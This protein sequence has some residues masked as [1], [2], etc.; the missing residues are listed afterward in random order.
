MYVCIYIYAYCNV[1]VKEVTYEKATQ[2][3]EESD[4]SRSSEMSALLRVPPVLKPKWQQQADIIGAR[5]S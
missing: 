5:T 1:I 2:S 3:R 4:S